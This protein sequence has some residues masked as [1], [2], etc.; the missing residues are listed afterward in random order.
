LTAIAA[1]GSKEM[2]ETLTPYINTL[3]LAPDTIPLIKKKAALSLLRLHRKYPLLTTPDQWLEKIEHLLKENDLGLLASVLALLH[4][5]IR[6][7]KS[8]YVRFLPDIVNLL[9]RIVVRKG[10]LFCFF[11]P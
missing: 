3:L 10:M 6:E 8:V 11:S 4:F 1:I 2:A 7:E 9:V 5:L